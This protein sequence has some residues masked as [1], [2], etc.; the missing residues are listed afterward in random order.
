MP[1]D[2]SDF[3]TQFL[4]ADDEIDVDE[5]LGGEIALLNSDFD[6]DDGGSLEEIPETIGR[7]W[8]FDFAKG[9]FVMHGMAPAEIRGIEQLKVWIE[10]TLRT[11]RLAHPIYTP[12]YGRDDPYAGI[13]QPFT[14]A[15]AGRIASDIKAALTYHDRITDVTDIEFDGS[16]A[17]DQL[18]VG[19]TVH[20]D[21]D[22][23]LL[24]TDVPLAET[25]TVQ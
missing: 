13:G 18:F 5:A 1:A 10:K 9:E 7:G 22:E 6:T 19:F 8:A 24:I 12:S 2:P 15:V 16:V 20:T 3:E 14:S 17:D 25:E 21:E 4:P 11:S 23:A